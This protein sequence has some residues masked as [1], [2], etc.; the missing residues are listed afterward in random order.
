VGVDFM[1]GRNYV[2]C[3]YLWDLRCALGLGCGKCILFVRLL[4][5]YEYVGER[6]PM[7]FPLVLW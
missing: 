4:E 6:V 7:I 2:I 3:V 5:G 1:G